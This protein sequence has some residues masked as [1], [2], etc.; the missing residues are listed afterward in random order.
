MLT[1][2]AILRICL[3][4]PHSVGPTH[5]STCLDTSQLELIDALALNMDVNCFSPE[6]KSLLNSWIPKVAACCAAFFTNFV[7]CR[8]YALNCRGKRHLNILSNFFRTL[9]FVHGTC[10][11]PCITSDS[12]ICSLPFLGFLFARAWLPEPLH[13]T[14]IVLFLFALLT[15]PARATIDSAICYNHVSIC[16]CVCFMWL[17]HHNSLREPT[18]THRH[19]NQPEAPETFSPLVLFVTF[20]PS[21]RTA[22]WPFRSE[23]WTKLALKL[24]LEACS[25]GVQKG[26]FNQKGVPPP[27][28][29]LLPLHLFQPPLNPPETQT[30]T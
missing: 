10:S 19:S 22:E 11:M 24:G 13:V 28:F 8:S 12:G 29:T 16:H 4:S 21:S 25:K 30:L 14:T 20:L 23:N 2:T 18:K 1:S 6:L 17:L 7:G 26:G 5:S 15:C 9:I 27:P 3:H